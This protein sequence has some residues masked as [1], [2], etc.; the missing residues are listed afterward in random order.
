MDHFLY[1]PYLF[2]RTWIAFYSN[3]IYL[4]EK[5]NGIKR[6]PDIRK[7]SQ[8]SF[9]HTEIF[10]AYGQ[11]YTSKPAFLQSYKGRTPNP[12]LFFHAFSNAHNLP[13]AI[14]TDTNDNENRNISIPTAFHVT[15]ISINIGPGKRIGT[16]GF[17][18]FINLLVQIADGS[19]ERFHGPIKLR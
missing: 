5:A 7:V 9:Q 16:S 12:T 2:S 1:T 15:A 10:V 4:A 3:R 14:P 18:M 13:A 17:D 6:I 19:S 8:N 11:T